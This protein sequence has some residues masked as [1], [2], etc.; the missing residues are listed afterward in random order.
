MVTPVLLVGVHH[1]AK[2]ETQPTVDL[3]VEALGNPSSSSSTIIKLRLKSPGSSSLAS[4]SVATTPLNTLATL[5]SEPDQDC[6]GLSA[7]SCEQDE[8]PDG[9]DF[10]YGSQE[11]D[12]P[13]KPLPGLFSNLALNNGSSDQ[14]SRPSPLQIWL[15]GS[16]LTVE[17]GREQLTSHHPLNSPS[18]GGSQPRLILLPQPVASQVLPPHLRSRARARPRSAWSVPCLRPERPTRSLPP[19]TTHNT[20]MTFKL[21]DR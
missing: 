18:T 7:I 12:L 19:P 6:G 2:H 14:L 17:I 8:E 16:V 10:T 4:S 21:S 11:D 3:G 9:F 15:Y 13:D 5:P 1:S 20:R